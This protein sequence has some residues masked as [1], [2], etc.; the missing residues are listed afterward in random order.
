MFY[1]FNSRLGS[2][3]IGHKFVVR[4]LGCLDQFC[5]CWLGGRCAI[6]KIVCFFHQNVA[7]IC[8]HKVSHGH[9]TRF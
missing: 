7:C 6:V 8:L 1:G 2:L 4:P 5:T 3:S 9:S